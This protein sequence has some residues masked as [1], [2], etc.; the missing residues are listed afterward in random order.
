MASVALTCINSVVSAGNCANLVGLS[1]L[2]PRKDR[3]PLATT[4]AIGNRQWQVN[5]RE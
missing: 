2:S 4:A 1:L 5:S 3:V